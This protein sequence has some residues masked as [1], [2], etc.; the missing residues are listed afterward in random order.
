MQN[1]YAREG[2]YDMGN[3]HPLGSGGNG[4]IVAM[5]QEWTLPVFSAGAAII[6]S[7][8]LGNVPVMSISVHSLSGLALP[9]FDH[10]GPYSSTL[11]GNISSTATT[12]TVT[13]T[14]PSGVGSP[15]AGYATGEPVSPNPDYFLMSAAVGD[16]FWIDS[17]TFQ[18]SRQ[19]LTYQLDGRS[20][21]R[22][23]PCHKS[24]RRRGRFHGLPECA[25]PAEFYR[26]LRLVG[27]RE[28]PDRHESLAMGDELWRSC[29]EPRQ[30]PR[31]LRLLLPAR[32]P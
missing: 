32:A 21:S 29:G 20:R 15:P 8:Y 30:L 4:H 28:Q 25:D 22:N 1:V 10:G 31:G 23:H 12:I 24:P 7:E 18:I 13:S 26:R 19:K 27:F 14:Y 5:V 9:P 3:G 11:F 17:E 16:T 6:S 2:A